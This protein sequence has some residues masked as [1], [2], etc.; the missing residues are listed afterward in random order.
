MNPE[1]VQG[2]H[3]ERVVIDTNVLI[4]AA[5]SPKGV[6]AQLLDQVLYMGA[7]VFSEYTFAELESRLWKPKFDRYL[8]LTIRRQLLHDFSAS[9]VWVQIS[10]NLAEQTYSRDPDDDKLVQA[11]I[12]GAVTRLISGDDDLLCL[13]S[14]DAIQTI[15][16][17]QALDEILD[18]KKS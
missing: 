5:L 6:P 18:H 12:A 10:S 4:S 14:I 1:A 7:L 16:P 8:S 17:R 3:Y 11:A 2:Y 15:S 13:G 9:A